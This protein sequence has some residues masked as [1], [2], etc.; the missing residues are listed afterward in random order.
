[1]LRMIKLHFQLAC[2]L[3]HTQKLF[4][5]PKQNNIDDHPK[6]KLDV[7]VTETAKAYPEIS[8]SAE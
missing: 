4:Y 7:T 3:N 1:M 6:E 5:D 8:V 2:S